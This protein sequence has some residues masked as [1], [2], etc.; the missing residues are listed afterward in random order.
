MDRIC[1]VISELGL[2]K[3]KVTPSTQILVT[4]FST[5]TLEESV[6]LV[7]RL[8]TAEINAELYPD[9]KDKLDKQLKYAD[10]KSIPY[11][12]IVGPEE[13]T[14]NK[15]TLKNMETGEQQTL[16]TDKIP[17]IITS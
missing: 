8:K 4:I 17:A 11:C 2:L 7:S 16:P 14:Q 3:D 15:V 9:P 5:D 10:R 12:A 6:K 13:I 1:D